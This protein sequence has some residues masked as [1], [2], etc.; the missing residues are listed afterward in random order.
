M[1]SRR[2]NGQSRGQNVAVQDR[3]KE[4][5][6]KRAQIVVSRN[7]KGRFLVSVRIQGTQQATQDFT[8]KS[9]AQVGA[10]RV[11]ERLETQGFAVQLRDTT[12]NPK[13]VNVDFSV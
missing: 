11:K 7:K 2:F 12:L 5:Q 1:A 4:S 6:T 3:I 8:T 10:Q 13:R 9:G